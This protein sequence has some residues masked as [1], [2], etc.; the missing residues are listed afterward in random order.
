MLLYSRTSML[1]GAPSEVMPAAVAVTE[2][3]K[4]ITGRDIGLWVGGP[5]FPVGTL[6][7][8][9]RIE[10]HSDIGDIGDALNADSKFN[11]LVGAM[12]QYRGGDTVDAVRS[13]IHGTPAD[14]LPPVGSMVSATTAQIANG[15]IAAA[16]Q[17]GS[18]V[19]EMVTGIT[20]SNVNFY[21]DLYGAFGSVSWLSGQPDGAGIDAA[22][23]ALAAAPEY[24]AKIDEGAPLFI[25]GTANQGIATRIA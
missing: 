11:D 16:M 12:M 21:R 23:A 2:R 4:D 7:W 17:W 6:N 1:V 5:G 15:N 24:L 20:G 9:M 19:A 22:Q 13:L 10:S 18:E 8:A 25:P 14:D 3:V